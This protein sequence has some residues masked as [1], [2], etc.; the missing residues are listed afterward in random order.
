MSKY[1]IFL[2]PRYIFKQ[3]I[4]M[5]SLITTLLILLS[6]TTNA[7]IA[8]D[9]ENAILDN[10]EH[11]QNEDFNAVMGDIHSQSPAYLQTQQMLYH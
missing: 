9:I 6:L 11:T 4:H 1:C 2:H 10:L 7:D 3:G 8:S 5:K